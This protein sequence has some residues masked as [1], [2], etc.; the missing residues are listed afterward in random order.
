[1]LCWATCIDGRYSQGN[2][3]PKCFFQHPFSLFEGKGRS[4]LRS[5]CDLCEHEKGARTALGMTLTR[6]SQANCQLEENSPSGPCL[7]HQRR[8]RSVR[9]RTMRPTTSHLVAGG[10]AVHP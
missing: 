9:S 7:A 5:N 1:M 6:T 8:C 4:T 3:S 10:A 2:G